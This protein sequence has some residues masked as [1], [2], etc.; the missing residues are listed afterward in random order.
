MTNHPL[1]E[2]AAEFGIDLSEN[3]VFIQYKGSEICIDMYCSCGKD[4]HFDGDFA[5]YVRCPYCQKVWELNS[6]ITTTE[7]PAGTVEEFLIRAA[8]RDEE[9]Q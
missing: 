6:H 7:V 1:D 3:F 5:R 2:V 9:D 8:R 4:S